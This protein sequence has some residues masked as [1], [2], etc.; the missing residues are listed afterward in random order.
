ML[1]DYL[2]DWCDTL[3]KP[4]VLLLDE[5]D[6]LYDDMLIS[7]L[8]QLRDGFQ[9]RPNHFSQ[10]IALVGLRDIRDFRMRARADNPSIGSGRLLI[11][12]QNL[13]SYL[14]F[15]RKKCVDCWTNIPW[16]RSRFFLR[17]F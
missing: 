3:A 5:V 6:A 4:L 13:F 2:T 9:T 14:Y 8:R 10:S 17:R 1:G 12:R 7:T 11:L 16:I 15:Q